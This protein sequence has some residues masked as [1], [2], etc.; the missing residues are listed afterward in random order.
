MKTNRTSKIIIAVLIL[1]T[2]GGIFLAFFL[3]NFVTNPQSAFN[4]SVARQIQSLAGQFK[5]L[6]GIRGDKGDQG[7]AGDH[8]HNG[9]N[10]STGAAGATGPQGPTGSTGSQGP[11]GPQGPQGE[12]GPQGVQGEQGQDAPRPQFRCNQETAQLQYKYPDDED[13]ANM[14]STCIPNGQ[15]G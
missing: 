12:T 9:Q 14:G 13:W 1:Q 7:P 6:E 11:A 2:I 4:E 15:G 5:P 3:Y 10:G 8:G